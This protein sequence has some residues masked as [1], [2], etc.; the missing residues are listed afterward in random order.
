MPLAAVHESVCGPSRRFAAS[1][2]LGRFW[3][4]ADISWQARSVGSVA[5]DEPDIG[6][7]FSEQFARAREG[8]L[9][10]PQ[11]HYIGVALGSQTKPP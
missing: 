3:R 1:Q 7:Q 2:Q 10:L 11:F 5:N 9:P 6:G 8:D 4:E